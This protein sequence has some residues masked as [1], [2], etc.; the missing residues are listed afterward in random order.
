M[1]ENLFIAPKIKVGFQKR[2]DTYT[3]KLGYVIYYDLS[4]KI[5]K[6]ASWESWRDK[7]ID[8]VEFNNKPINGFTINEDVSH[9]WHWGRGRTMIRIHDPRD[10]EIEVTADNLIGIL[11]HTDCNKRGLQGEFVYAW[12]GKELVLL[13]TNSEQYQKSVQYTENLGKTVKSKDM[14]VGAVYAVKRATHS[15]LYDDTGETIYIGRYDFGKYNLK[16]EK[17]EKNEY[18]IFC[19]KNGDKPYFLKKDNLSFLSAAKTDVASPDYPQ[20]AEKFYNDY[21]SKRIVKYRLEPI[22][23]KSNVGLNK[24]LFLADGD[25]IKAIE[26]DSGNFRSQYY[27]E[28]KL[29]LIKGQHYCRKLNINTLKL[30]YDRTGGYSYYDKTDSVSADLV[31]NIIV[32][33]ADGKEYATQDFDC[34]D[35]G[36]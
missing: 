28:S 20:L 17:L 21:F 7:K 36:I 29:I 27:R 1:N 11:M 19:F 6:E 30:S 5:H 34:F 25:F 22:D 4:G 15:Y 33:Q 31:F 26:V 10:F 14:I 35:L 8:P 12:S 24:I 16:K 18:Y 2:N 32:T 13:P 23:L 9:G 3:G